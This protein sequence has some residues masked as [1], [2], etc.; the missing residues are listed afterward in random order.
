MGI[1]TWVLHGLLSKA[2]GVNL[3]FLLTFAVEAASL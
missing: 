3:D 1:L 2:N